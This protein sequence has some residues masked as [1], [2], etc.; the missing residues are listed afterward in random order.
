MTQTEGEIKRE[1]NRPANQHVEQHSEE[2]DGHRGG[3]GNQNYLA[4]F[5]GDGE[6]C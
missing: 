3:N 5:T 1:V 2:D 4:A 6:R